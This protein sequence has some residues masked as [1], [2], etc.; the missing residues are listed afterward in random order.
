MGIEDRSKQYDRRFVLLH[1]VMPASSELKTH[2]DFML[3]AGDSL[4]TFRLTRLPENQPDSEET[5]EGATTGEVPIACDH[6]EISVLRLPNHR[7]Y[8]LDYAGEV[9]GG[10]GHVRQLASGLAY[11]QEAIH[12]DWSELLLDSNTLT[13]E[14]HFLACSPHT[15]TRLRILSWQLVRHTE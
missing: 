11:L 1:H 12:G 5:P 4:L 8:Y 7:R 3:E 2:W 15:S 9:S 13:A 6:E 10:R 14:L